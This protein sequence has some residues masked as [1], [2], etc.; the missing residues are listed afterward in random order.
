M[1]LK[2]SNKKVDA[3]YELF[4]I[5]NNKLEINPWMITDRIKAWLMADT[6]TV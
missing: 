5:E 1:C 6:C 4:A 3:Q 2:T